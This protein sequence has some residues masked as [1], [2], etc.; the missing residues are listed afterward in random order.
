MEGVTMFSVGFGIQAKMTELGDHAIH[1]SIFIHKGT[2]VNEWG[3]GEHY[4]YEASNATGNWITIAT[5]KLGSPSTN[6]ILSAIDVSN[7]QSRNLTP[8]MDQFN[9]DHVIVR[10]F[11]DQESPSRDHSIAQIRSTID[12]EKT[13]GGYVWIYKGLD[14]RRQVESSLSI[15]HQLDV[16][17]PILWIDVEPYN[18][19]LP[20]LDELVRTVEAC[21][22][23]D[24]PCGIYTGKWAWDRL[25]TSTFSHLPLWHAEYGIEPTLELANPYGGWT[26]CV[27][28]QY[29]STPIDRNIILS[30]YT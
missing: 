16:T 19:V 30:Q 29:T 5:P 24:Q 28:H 21:D 23:V 26:T 13:V 4:D 14:P 22:N 11:H 17:I 15:V 27:C 1:D 12:H 10:L 20:T 9:P 2:V 3:F 7:F 18:N 25:N 8:Y 6:T